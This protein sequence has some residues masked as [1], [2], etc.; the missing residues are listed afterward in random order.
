MGR[1]LTITK[2]STFYTKIKEYRFSSGVVVTVIDYSR[3][4][5]RYN[6]QYDA[7]PK[8]G[9]VFG[10]NNVTVTTTGNNKRELVRQLRH[11]VKRKID[12]VYRAVHDR[13]KL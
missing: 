2:T 6:V 13:L 9:D 4:A 10:F 11:L 8:A 5:N 3:A 12:P 7:E 1:F